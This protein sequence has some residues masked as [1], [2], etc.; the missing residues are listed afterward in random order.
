M[1]SLPINKYKSSVFAA[2]S[3][4]NLLC[5]ADVQTRT[6]DELSPDTRHPI[7]G[8]DVSLN[9]VVQE[10]SGSFL[11]V[12][13]VAKSPTEAT[14]ELF[15]V[16]PDSIPTFSIDD[17]PIQE[18][19]ASG[20]WLRPQ[21]D[22]SGTP[23]LEFNKDDKDPSGDSTIFEVNLFSLFQS[24]HVDIKKAYENCIAD[25]RVM[26]NEDNLTIAE[27]SIKDFW[28]FFSDLSPSQTATLTFYP[29]ENLRAVWDDGYGN[30]VGIQ[31]RGAGEY[32]YVI[33]KGAKDSPD[34]KYDAGRG[35]IGVVKQRIKDYKLESL[36]GIYGG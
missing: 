32:Q 19:L 25:L 17:K 28:W 1:I 18:L 6:T 3:Y 4:I 5:F 10:P 21:D 26:A 33:F 15:L 16:T 24:E 2:I 23:A 29:N 22:F 14:D 8:L 27:A 7:Q 9:H 35:D 34:R 36:L 20:L 11:R 12:L 30:H 31:F 13:S